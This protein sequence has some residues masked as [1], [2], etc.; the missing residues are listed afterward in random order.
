[1]PVSRTYLS[2]HEKPSKRA[3][4]LS[5]MTEIKFSE[6]GGETRPTLWGEGK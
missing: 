5:F 6:P 4:Y 3:V 1:M 2:S